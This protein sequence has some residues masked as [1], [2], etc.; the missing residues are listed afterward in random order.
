MARTKLHK[1]APARAHGAHKLSGS[2]Y[3]LVTEA[4]GASR[5]REST[6]SEEVREEE[7]PETGQGPAE[8]EQAAPHL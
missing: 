2:G 8:S 1:L 6:T 7:V 3:S 4:A 5:S